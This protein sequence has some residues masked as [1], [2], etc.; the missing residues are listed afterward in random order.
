[1]DKKKILFLV[2]LPP[3]VHGSAVMSQQIVD[4]KII[5][6]NI[7]CDF[8]NIA[9][10]RTM[11][12][13]SRFTLMKPLRHL[14][15]FMTVFVKLLL[16]KYDACYIALTCHG[17]G[18]LKDAPFALLCK[19]FG[20]R[21]I[22]H[23]HNKGMSTC[24]GRNPYK[25]LMPLVYKDASVLLLSWR[26]YNDIKPVVDKSHVLI[27]PN[28]IPVVPYSFAKVQNDVPHILFL[29]NLIKSKG[30]LDLLDACV[31]LK[32]NH[33]RF[34][35]DFVGK[36]T[37]E[38]TKE[39]FVAEIRSRGLE[40]YV[41]YHGPLY[42]ESKEKFL[43]SSDIFVFP[44]VN[45][46]FGLVILEAMQH[47]LPVITYAE[48]G[49]PDIIEDCETGFIVKKNDVS[50]LSAKIEYLIAHSDVAKTLGMAGLAKYNREFR[51]EIWEKRMC[52]ILKSICS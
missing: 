20:K 29:S 35:C 44:S 41:I 28:G 26:L 49:I 43:S 40:D 47:M 11:G 36:E 39:L 22:I 1:M 16:N 19:A 50:A 23:Q 7:D 51:L 30:V 25:W 8:V 3:P 46:T 33:T 27:C 5:R 48:G 45:E 31:I 18:F 14:S 2:P 38:I 15:I 52:H 37:A 34:I 42:G 4:S 6:E 21:L 9:T 32:R 10:S 24:I 17:K 13:I 12:E